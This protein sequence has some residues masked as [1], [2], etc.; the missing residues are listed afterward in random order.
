MRNV[1]IPT[2]RELLLSR[3][4]LIGSGRSERQLR[5]DVAAGILV[6]VH[7]GWYMLAEH[8]AGLW[9]ESQHLARVVA[10]NDAAE[11]PPVFAFTSAAAILGVGVYRVRVMRVHALY[12]DAE[13]R[14]VGGVIRHRGQLDEAD[15]VEVD[16]ILCTSP[17]R[18]AY[19]LA[20][21]ASAE[22][23]LVFID[24]ILSR[25]GGD[26]RQYDVAAASAWL[27]H[28]TERVDRMPGAR[29][30]RHARSLLEVADGR[31][32]KPLEVVT[33]LQL[34]RL[35]FGQPA[36][37][38]Q[39]AAPSRGS[40][41]LDLEIQEVAT[42]YECD[43]EAKYTDE[44]LRSGRTLEEVLLAEKQREDWVRGTTRKGFV[45]GGNAHATSPEVLA[46]RLRSFGIELPQRRSGLFLPRRPLLYGQ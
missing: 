15:I 36:I 1:D 42:F 13:R 27:A 20:R 45:R 40:Y 8:W 38:V 7:R 43:G 44:A 22:V 6:R 39:V 37:Q 16:G 19:D 33:K 17:L 11:V 31:S 5:E 35:G 24:E 14:T 29:G 21:L 4:D 30:I 26:P 3:D 23:A 18:T 32:Q 28:L 10:V 25:I 46:A 34:R 41:W 9:P 2:V 12:P